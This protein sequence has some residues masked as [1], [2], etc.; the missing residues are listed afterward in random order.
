MVRLL[1][2]GDIT[3]SELTALISE[4][5]VVTHDVVDRDASGEGDS[6][7]EVLALFARESLLNLFFN[8]G[9]DSTTDGGDVGS[10]NTKFRGL[11]K[12]S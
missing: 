3:V 9:I 4:G 1:H 2:F 11:G 6:T 10:G 8:H 12:A 5:G 7:L